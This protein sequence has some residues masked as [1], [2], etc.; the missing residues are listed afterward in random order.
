M[1]TLV[2]LPLEL[3]GNLIVSCQAS[4]TSPF[5]D[6]ASMARFAQAAV[7]GGARGIRADGPE[8]IRAIRNAVTV[9]IV[10]IYKVRQ[11]DGE[12]LITPSLEAAKELVE[13][14][15]DS[16]ALD[17]SARGQRYGALD[18]LQQ[19]KKSLGV[20]VLADIA[21]VEEAVRATKA[22]ADA[23][24][25]TLRGYT[26]ET[27]DVV[28]FEPSFIRELVR[29]VKVPVIAEGHIG[30]PQQI[31]AA[32]DAGAFAIIIGSAITRPEMITQ[33]FVSAL[34]DWR[35]RQDSTRTFIGIDLGG[36]NTKFGIV[37]SEGKL[38]FQSVLP[39]PWN[40][41]R[42]MLLRHAER[43]ITACLEEAKGRG[44][45]PEAIGLATAGW[46][47][48]TTGQIVYATGNLPG[49]M[50][51]NPG[52]HLRDV[53]GLPVAVE[54]DANALAVAEKQFGAAKNATD[55]VC[56]TLGTGV[57]GGCYIGGRLNRGRHFFANALGHI[58]I[59]PGG[60]PC[61]CGKAGCL[62]AYANASAL[63]RYAA[64]GNFSSCEEIITAANSGNQTARCAIQALAKHLAMGCAS[65]VNL[66]DPELL[67]LAGGLAQN[68]SHLVTAFTEELKKRVTVWPERKLRI[69]ASGLGY[70][71]GVLGAAAVASAAVG[72]GCSGSDGSSPSGKDALP[73]SQ[74]SI[75]RTTS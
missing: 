53:F 65:I 8:D 75:A 40:E 13:A 1:E 54:N 23:V 58:P 72:E 70:S 41:G 74:R 69:E 32:L 64:H 52:V 36:T 68:N 3:R 4:E 12:I 31:C 14:G 66:L 42:G 20:P 57:G 24:L 35:R 30:T 51:A 9:P 62:E 44:L 5:R 29:A 37:S 33:M 18:R 39:T 7:E 15:A 16:V 2:K 55:F 25:S 56:I 10:G 21:T 73:S 46:P 63:M 45:E 26:R 38:I 49:W 22:G 60:V 17:C 71:A 47:D 59:V 61:T 34:E 67:I 43:C 50:G 28:E 11:D 6:A 48:P 27:R 19:I